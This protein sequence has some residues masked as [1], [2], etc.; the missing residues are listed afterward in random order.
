MPNHEVIVGNVGSVYFGKS[1]AKAL[2]TYKSYVE[3]SNQHAG[4][5]CHGEDVILLVDGGM[6]EEHTGHL[7]QE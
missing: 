4:T 2:A 3:A 7:R 6:E 1:R 5:R